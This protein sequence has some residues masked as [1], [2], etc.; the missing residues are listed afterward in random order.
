MNQNWTKLQ[1]YLTGLTPE[2][3]EVFCRLAEIIK[4]QV[5]ELDGQEEDY[6]I[7]YMM[8]DALEY[9]LILKNSVLTGEFEPDIP[10]Q[11]GQI[12]KETSPEAAN[13]EN[14]KK[15]RYILSIQQ[16]NGNLFTLYFDELIE[17]A[18]CYRYHEIG[19]FWVKGQEQW[20]QLVYIIG[21][22]YDKYEFFDDRFCSEEEQQ[23]LPL[24]H[25]QPFRY[26]SPI[27][28]PL[29]HYAEDVSGWDTMLGLA[30]EA[31]DRSFARLLRLSRPLP[32][33][34]AQPMLQWAM[35]SPRRRKLYEHIWNKVAAASNRYG[36]RDYGEAV[37]AQIAEQRR[38]AAKTL[39]R[40]GYAGAYP[41][42]AKG[43]RRIHVCEEHPF[44][45]MEYENY[46]FQI[47]LMVSEAAE[48][49]LNAGFF[50]GRGRRG[51]IKK[52]ED[53]TC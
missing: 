51:E 25:F 2:L 18:A 44:T 46:D 27:S 11:R 12:A 39:E 36:S 32:K 22:L 48:E 28:H 49:G 9:Y 26:F 45:T 33:A 41:D 52:L 7:P 30:D 29:D 43:N 50:R 42:F 15:Q 8:N 6:R 34:L 53:L 35:Q 13:G 31:G 47:Q 4:L 10:V 38:Q 14:S 19:H 37:N 40:L 23:L 5:F 16:E 21:T 1:T 20:R 24:M 17:Q 3:P